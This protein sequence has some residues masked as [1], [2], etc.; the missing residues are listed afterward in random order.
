[1]SSFF[2]DGVVVIKSG[3]PLFNH[4]QGTYDDRFWV[5]EVYAA[6]QAPAL[7]SR[8]IAKAIQ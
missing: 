5:L 1:L 6:E 8:P 2:T 4:P 7:A 3:K